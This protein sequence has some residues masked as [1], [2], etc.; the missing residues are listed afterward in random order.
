MNVEVLVLFQYR[1]L[2]MFDQGYYIRLILDRIDIDD[3][4]DRVMAIDFD[5]IHKPVE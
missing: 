4:D 3:D 5:R 2:A 1:I